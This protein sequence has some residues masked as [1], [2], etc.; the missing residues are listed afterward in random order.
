MNFIKIALFVLPFLAF[1]QKEFHVFPSDNASKPGKATG[2]G[3]LNKPWDLQTALDQ[4]ANVVNGG[5]TV[6]IH[7]GIYNG[8]FISSLQSTN[9]DQIVVSAFK[10]DKVILNGNIDSKRRSVLEVRGR[11]V[12]FKNLE[13]TF[14]GKFSRKATEALFLSVS[15]L[16]HVSGVNCQFI[17]LKIHNNPG[18][19]FGS[20]KRAGG[21]LIYGCVI[22][23]NGFFS[24]KRGSGVGL[25]VQ[26]ESDQTRRIENNIIFNNFYKGIEVWSANKNAKD[27]YV[28]NVRLEDNIVFNNGLPAGRKRDNIIVA[29]DDRNGINLAKNIVL[30]NNILYHNTDFKNNQIGGDA[31]SLTLG[32]STRANLENVVVS[33]NI[34]IGRNN[35][36]RFNNARSLTFQNNIAYCGYV[37]LNKAVLEN[38]SKWNFKNNTYYTKRNVSFRISKHKDYTITDW[39][40]EFPIDHK[41]NWKHIKEFN[42]PNVLKITQN[43]YDKSKFTV[44]VFDKFE[45]DVTVK[46]TPFNVKEGQDYNLRN[47][48][49]NEVISSGK[50]NAKGEIIIAIGDHNKTIANFGVYA[51][52]LEAQKV[53]KKSFFKRLFGWIF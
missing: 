21:S 9:K 32:Y 33:D 47:V 36:L 53:A 26:N 38:I 41:S 4:L 5:D 46:L 50:V 8:R 14:L 22:Y 13:I 28:K 37:H 35:A 49:S 2:N 23:N 15:G 30:R 45:N 7:E 18:S 27:E 43:S 42:L 19:G 29:S 16:D 48:A 34:I 25:Y 1:S 20:W 6:W 11:N 12:T 24:R 17:N 39:R 3:S 51:I 10:N 44:A 31:P 40:K 52:H